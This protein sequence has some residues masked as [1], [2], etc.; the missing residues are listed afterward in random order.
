MKSWGIWSS[1]WELVGEVVGSG[2][3]GGME[4]RGGLVWECYIEVWN[5]IRRI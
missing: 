3:V 4:I 5:K 2:L 1:A